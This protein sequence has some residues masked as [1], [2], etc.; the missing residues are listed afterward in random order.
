MNILKYNAGGNGDNLYGIEPL[1]YYILNLFL[2]LGI[3]WPFAALA[4]LT[5][6]CEFVSLVSRNGSKGIAS[7]LMDF[8][9]TLTMFAAA[10]LWILILFSRPHKAN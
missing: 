9:P 6:L 5:E 10:G 4:P 1:R 7:S 3:S 8:L 2:N